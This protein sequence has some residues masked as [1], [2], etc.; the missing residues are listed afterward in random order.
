MGSLAAAITRGLPSGF[1]RNRNSDFKQSGVDHSFLPALPKKSL[2]RRNS[3]HRRWSRKVPLKI[4]N[5]Y[6]LQADRAGSQFTSSWILDDGPGL[7]ETPKR[8]GSSSINALRPMFFRNLATPPKRS[9]GAPLSH[10]PLRFRLQHH[11]G[12]ENTDSTPDWRP[13]LTSSLFPLP[14]AKWSRLTTEVACWSRS[15]KNAGKW[16]KARLDHQI[17]SER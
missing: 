13:I 16:F 4:T 2:D 17:A 7:S 14:F 9:F 10:R 1:R 6:D 15:L 11:N 12:M 8:S 3:R 5:F